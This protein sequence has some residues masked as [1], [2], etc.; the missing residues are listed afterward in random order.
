[1]ATRSTATQIAARIKAHKRGDYTRG[2]RLDRAFAKALIRNP[3]ISPPRLSGSEWAEKF[4][5]IPKSTGAE[6]GPITLY[7]Y[8][9]EPMDAMCDPSIGQLTF[10]K[11]ARVGY[12]R[13][14]TL[15]VG[16]HLHHDPTL[17]AIAQPVKEDAEDFGGTE[18]APMLRET[19]VLRRMLRPSR[20]GEK[21]DKATFYK[22]SNGAS[23]RLVGAAADDAF[24][25]YSARF[26]AADEIDGD[27]WTPDYKS[28][29]D[30]LSLF[31][32]RGEKFWNRKL[33]AG[34]TPLL[35]E[36]SRIA[37]RWAKSDQ[38]R[39]FVPCPQCGE[40]QYLEWG[41]KDVPHGIKWDSEDG[42]IT[43]I[44]Y[45]GKCGC[46]IDEAK[47]PWMDANGEW[48]P[49]N[50]SGDH[51]GYHL[52]TGMSLDLNASWKHIA[53]E[54]LDAQ[55]DP[56][57]KIQPFVN[58]RLGRTY[59]ATYG[60]EA[61]ASKFLE[62]CELYDAEVPEGVRFLT[63]GGDVQ[64]GENARIEASVYGWGHGL[65]CWFIG[66]FVLHGDPAE[67]E[68]WN[69]LDLLLKRE[70]KKSDGTTLR[71]RSAAIDSGGHYTAET[72]SFCN[73]RRARRVWAIKGRS[74]VNGRRTPVWPRKPS[75]ALGNVWY[76]IG[77]NAARDFAYGS[78]HI[79]KPGPRF[80]HF[81]DQ[82]ALGSREIDEEFFE[83]M[84]RETL[85]TRRQGF[86]EWDKP[87]KPRE[88]G[89]CLVYAYAA[90]CGLQAL[91]GRYVAM[92][93][94]VAAEPVAANDNAPTE[95][96]A[97]QAPTPVAPQPAAQKQRHQPTLKVTQ[98]DR[99]AAKR[100]PEWIPKR[101]SK[102]L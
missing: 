6:S 85:V 17:C 73:E 61:K 77:G 58:L 52:W 20:R 90:V 47:K 83:Q 33:I 34:S 60:Q 65:E 36:T 72:Y 1:M 99:A 30:K 79:D 31:W 67:R 66:H 8:Q 84:T 5:R 27:G 43:N 49:T 81:T 63:L 48:R 13:L 35:E 26:M 12:T 87:K 98:P 62:R 101:R 45:V 2:R 22:L 21:Q 41:G 76:M 9:R 75:S 24:R 50:P 23:V 40:M 88:V 94:A 32:T 82:A 68:V 97:E 37:A 96:E 86:T 64:S 4:G 18:I 10:M 70:F 46:I 89:V 78:L 53:Q 15:A 38:R 11:A 93:K 74:E 25:R 92:G 29:G 55:A 100:A 7:G 69:S 39:Y 54:W 71:V 16:Y 3:L 95:A 51:R 59:R 42:K 44:W 19:P 56:I 14:F 102:W 80:I 91:S 57:N 28:Q